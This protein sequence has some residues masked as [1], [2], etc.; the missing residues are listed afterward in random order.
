[1]FPVDY[2][3]GE[4]QVFKKFDLYNFKQNCQLCVLLDTATDNFAVVGRHPKL[5]NMQ[6]VKV[7]ARQRLMRGGGFWVHLNNHSGDSQ[8]QSHLGLSI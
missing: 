5:L 6:Q 8:S 4:N 1:M 2:E 7:N 3:N